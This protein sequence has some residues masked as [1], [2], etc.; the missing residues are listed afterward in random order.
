[1]RILVTVPWGERLGGAEAMLHTLLQGGA[2][3]G[4]EM[5][6]VFFKTGSWPAE[7]I[8]AGFCVTD[9]PAGRVRHL[10]RWAATVARLARLF[11]QRDP[12][13]ILN[14][15]AKTQLYGSPAAMLAGMTDRVMW[16]QHGIPEEDWLDRCATALPAIAVGCSANTVAEAQADLFPHRPTLVVFPGIRAPDAV[17]RQASF[18]LPR[19]ATVIGIVGRLHPWKRQDRLL[20]AHLLLQKR[21][22]YVHTLIVGGDAHELSPRYA[23][24]L[25]SL[26]AR[27]EL[28][29]EVTMTGQVEDA[30]PY[31]ACMDVLV[32]AS[33]PES[34]G[35]VLLEAMASGVPVVAV[36]SGGPAEF[37]EAGRTGVLARSG[38]PAALADALEPL[39][40]SPK[41][42]HAIGEAGRQSFLR[43]FTS[44]AMCGR[45]FEQIERLAAC[46]GSDVTS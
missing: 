9:M 12:E 25:G 38:E 24:S 46:N 8:D 7:L 44:A 41:L 3:M 20:E 26:I 10:H 28:D 1:M 14:W 21:G 36:N 11:R 35:L 33:N 18:D 31:V 5:E 4:H 42:R 40:E 27:L 16:W 17:S 43:E 37:I 30:F 23:A 22:H 6:P 34:F 39:L 2:D 13:L 15:T 45:F 29:G 19:N 32:N